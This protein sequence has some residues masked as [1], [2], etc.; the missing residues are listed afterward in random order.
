MEAINQIIRK[1]VL[2]QR[3]NLV[4]RFI[5]GSIHF[6][7]FFLI[8]WLS[9]FLTDSVFYFKTE[10][11]WFIL[12]LNSSLT[13]YLFYQFVL[14]PVIDS[15][16]LSEKKDLTPVTKYI[17][18]R[19]P[20]IADRLTNI[21]QLIIS[22]PPGSSSSIKQYAIGQFAQKVTDINFAKKLVLKDYF[23]PF[24]FMLPV[25]MGSII[26][27]FSLSGRLSLSAKRVL[28][29]AGEYAI[30]PWYEFSVNPG[31]ASIISGESLE[32]TILYQGPE[33]DNCMF[34]YRNQG[35]KN[36]QSK[37]LRKGQNNYHLEL[38]NIRKPFDYYVQAIPA[39]PA[40]W[41]NKL[42]SKMY[43]I[44]TLNPPLI[45]EILVEIQPPFYTKLP[46]RF[47]DLNVG[48]IIAYPGSKI[49]ISG[50]VS[51]NLK[52]AEMV[53]S[54]DEKKNCR[55][56]ENKFSYAFTINTDKSYYFNISDLEDLH[57]QDPIEYSITVLV[58]QFP[59]VEITEPGED[60]EIAAD[61]AVNL[62]IEGNDDFG[63]KSLN[64][65][66]Q[67]QGKIKE[68]RDSTWQNIPILISS[69]HAK[70]F[71]QSYLWNF[72]N[73][74]VSFEDYVKYYVTL[75]D[76]DI[77]KG[78]K[79]S[80]SNTYYIRFPSLE[81]LFDEFEM[82]QNENLE[83]TEDLAKESEELK[84]DLEEIRREMKREKEIDWERKRSL[85]ATI[86]KQK[87][88]QEKLQKIEE[89]LEQAIKKMENNQL[90]S[91]EIL[92]KYRQLQNLFQEIITPELLQA[93]NELQNALNNLDQKS[94]QRSLEKFKLNQ[95]RF[96][97]NLERTL[98]LFEKVKL[99]QELDRMVKM[100]EQLKKEQSE[101]S[102]ALQ[103]ENL[104][105]KNERESLLQKEE[106]QK[107]LLERIE[108]SL[109][110]LE[111]SQSLDD[112]PKSRNHLEEAKDT[113]SQLQNQMQNLMNQMS[114]GNQAQAGK[115]SKQV[116]RQMEQLYSDLKK[117]QDEMIMS[118][119]KKI[120]T[121][122]QKITEN[123]LKLSENE[124]NLVDNTKSLSNYTDRFPE[125]AESQQKILEGMS[126]V[127]RDIIDLSHETF[128]ISPQISKS[129]GSANGNMRK[130][131]SEL[132]NRRQNTASNFQRQAMAGINESILSMNQ[133]MEMMSSASSATGFE[134]YLEQMR[135]L[136]GRQGQ[137]NQESLNF[138]KQNQGSLSMEQ[139]GYLRRMAAEQRA[140]QESMENMAN[141]MQNRSDILGRLD[142]MANE[143][144]EVVEDLQALNIDRKTIERQQQILS[145][146]LDA[147]K[148]V[149]E[150]EYSKKRLAEVG[151][152]YRRKS[153]DDPTN[154]ED[155]RMKQ[156]S[157]DLIRALQE[158]FNPD[159]E[160][161]IEEYF[162]AL[163]A[164][165]S[166]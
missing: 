67:I 122:M 87:K 60:I 137:L 107:D 161:L 40:E 54:D 10:V 11:R 114:A 89:D 154:M 20:S 160:K 44:E 5:A 56:R 16:L 81:Q 92:E 95:E 150:K 71:Q 123:L 63:F 4:F 163:N 166:N 19:F 143:M 80:R 112:Y 15:F 91:P 157:L 32:I 13:I 98:A 151:K 84:K 102:E 37:V 27:I 127:I 153:P 9:T 158:G 64:L 82:T 93:M 88:I 140:I 104:L 85:E 57:N 22:E 148:S 101:I 103:D 33:A 159:Y 23:L 21:Y 125:V 8:I 73:L 59:F 156:L 117:A 99:E 108:K 134:Q 36:L 146:M 29:P 111:K 128:F 42:I 24:S 115:S 30:V 69:P 100:A 133:S 94:G 131:L 70:Y 144:G 41:R 66:Y 113:G 110:E 116:G 61:G 55:I 162:R 65:H 124:E 155:P 147:Q 78:P 7:I 77:I 52:K 68:T 18:E 136:S 149:R 26:L 164:D 130:S 49:N 142:H 75:T 97:E 74:P 119:K 39:F 72:A 152:E 47:L 50:L 83:S 139:Q 48:D 35:E 109:A 126:H 121:K 145:R 1:I 34:W 118:D 106:N 12:I 53:F 141:E 120:L 132:E 58:D 2:F 90:F 31:D 6:F 76:N 138:F 38:D 96:K 105:N 25:L 43:T 135:K 129:L 165:I 3:K 62:V 46:K 14:L 17:G 79:K 28:N 45:N 51:K 86:E